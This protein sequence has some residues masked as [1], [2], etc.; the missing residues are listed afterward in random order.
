MDFEQNNNLKKYILK[1]SKKYIFHCKHSGYSKKV[2]HTANFS[3][4]FGLT[5][6]VVSHFHV[7]F[8]NG[9]CYWKTSF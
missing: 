8:R 7:N 3:W 9:F 5:L 1:K 2:S 6:P 4:L